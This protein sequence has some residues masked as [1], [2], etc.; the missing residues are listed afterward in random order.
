MPAR[1]GSRAGSNSAC[2]QIPGTTPIKIASSSIW[3]MRSARRG[4]RSASGPRPVTDRLAIGK[5]EVL[6]RRA[7]LGARLTE[8]KLE[9]SDLHARATADWPITARD[10]DFMNLGGIVGAQVLIESDQDVNPEMRALR[11][12]GRPSQGRLLLRCRGRRQVARARASRDAFVEPGKSLGRQV[13]RLPVHRASV[14]GCSQEGAQGQE[15]PRAVAHCAG[16]GLPRS[17]RSHIQKDAA[18]DGSRRRRA[19]RRRATPLDFTDCSTC[20]CLAPGIS[21]AS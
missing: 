9:R 13:P 1:R 3:R 18:T 19:S 2:R 21:F 7:S 17:R 20:R 5:G 16:E 12:G 6:T 14:T 10:A 4:S 8:F 15:E 11:E